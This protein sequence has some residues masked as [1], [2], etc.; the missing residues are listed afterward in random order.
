MLQIL[1]LIL[2]I[3]VAMSCTK[4]STDPPDEEP[5]VK[6]KTNL[7]LQSSRLNRSINYAVLLPDNYIDETQNFPV[8]YLL[9]GFGDDEKAWYQAVE[10]LFTPTDI[11]TALDL[12]FFVMPQG[13]NTYWLDRYNGNYPYM[14]MLINELVPEID[15][16]F[17][18]P[19]QQPINGL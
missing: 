8:V 17:F 14:Q 9:H 3:T 1:L 19:N 10:F 11:P 2:I 13:F 15:T 5:F 12:P 6:L 18:V 4:E 16:L 7:Q